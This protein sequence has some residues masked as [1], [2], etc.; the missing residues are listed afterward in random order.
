[1][2]IFSKFPIYGVRKG[3]GLIYCVGMRFKDQTTG[4]ILIGKP[5]VKDIYFP[6]ANVVP[7][8]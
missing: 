4:R 5:L 2:P 3:I 8:C 1:M 7:S 6:L